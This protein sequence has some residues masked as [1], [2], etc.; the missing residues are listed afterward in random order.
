MGH[1]Q[2]EYEDQKLCVD[3]CPDGFTQQNVTTSYQHEFPKCEKCKGEVANVRFW[4]VL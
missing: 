2:Y 1:I 4:Y 3:K